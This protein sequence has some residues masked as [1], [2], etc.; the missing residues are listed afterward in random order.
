M[1]LNFEGFKMPQWNTPTV[2]AQ[3]EDEKRGHLP[4]YYVYYRIYRH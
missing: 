1:E 2:R 4:R 3:K